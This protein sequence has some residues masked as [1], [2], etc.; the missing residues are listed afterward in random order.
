MSKY[1]VEKYNRL[2]D[3]RA[4]SLYNW[5]IEY[6][7]ENHGRRASHAEM[8]KAQKLSRTILLSTIAILMKSDLYVIEDGQQG[9]ARSY[10]LP[11]EGWTHPHRSLM[12]SRKAFYKD[13]LLNHFD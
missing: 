13:S 9:N 6:H 1:S 11:G 8:R 2:T 12:E 5:L 4:R 7:Y 10:H 3:P